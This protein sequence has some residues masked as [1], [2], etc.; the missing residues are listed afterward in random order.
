MQEGE[1]HISQKFF[2]FGIF[3]ICGIA[4]GSFLN[5]DAKFLLVIASLCVILRIFV[6]S[7]IKYFLICLVFFCLGIFYYQLRQPVFD[8]HFI[9]SYN[10]QTVTFIGNTYLEPDKRIDHTKLSVRSSLLEIGNDFQEMHGNVLLKVFRFPQYEYG[11][12]LK[13]TC[14]LQ[15]P[16]SFDSFN[17][18]NYLARYNIYSVC[19]Y[20]QIIMLNEGQGNRII[21]MVYIIKYIVSKR[22]QKFVHEPYA[23]FLAGLIVGERRGIDPKLMAAFNT[24]GTTHIIA[25]SGYNIT[26]LVRVFFLVLISLYIRRQYAIW[27]IY[28]GLIGFV[29]I[30]GISASVVRAAIMGGL[31]VF[32]QF[33]GRQVLMKN[34]LVATVLCM[35]MV[36]PNILMFDIGFQLS[37]LATIGL[38]YFTKPLEKCFVWLPE[39]FGIRESFITT[40]TSTLITLPLILF[41]FK[42]FAIHAVLVNMLILPVIPVAMLLGV[43]L[44]SISFFSTAFSFICG[45][46]VSLILKYIIIIVTF[47]AS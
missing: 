11:Q 33:N 42:R 8:E 4:L 10:G 5:F 20:P 43:F 16:K 32:A 9:S 41:Y 35:I 29:F 13:I 26:I 46:F 1:L 22:I 36:N 39:L 3:F 23:S 38:I 12:Q 19:Y 2:W 21:K 18:K 45:W 17:Y 28:I 24:T 25:V 31:V 15:E 30:S 40:L 44:I 14:T 34:L 27:F 37:F 6:Q 7:N 47:F